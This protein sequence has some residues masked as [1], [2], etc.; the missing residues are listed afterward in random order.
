MSTN[1]QRQAGFTL[2]ELIVAIVIIGVGVAG[3]LAAFYMTVQASADPLIHKQK[4]S[5]AEGMLE[6]ILLKPFAVSGTPPVNALVACGGPVA[7]RRAFNDVLDYTG[8]ATTGICDI[9]GAAVLGLEDYNVAVV[10]DPAASLTDGATA[11]AGGNTLRVS[12][13]VTHG[14]ESL[15][16][17]GWRT[18]FGS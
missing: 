3:V 10:V 16:I 13:T 9:E 17:T 7:V 4:L 6:E 15:R 1:Q 12:V 18:N 14:T 2:V 5:I 8:Y 11:V